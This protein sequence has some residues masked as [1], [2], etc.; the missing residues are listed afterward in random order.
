[1]PGGDRIIISLRDAPDSYNWTQMSQTPFSLWVVPVADAASRRLG[2]VPLRTVEGRFFGVSS[3]S[4]RPDGKMLAY[5]VD[6][7]A[8]QQTWVIENLVQFIKAGGGK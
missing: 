3:L 1:M 7:G 8:F 6:E 2:S 5:Q 4:V